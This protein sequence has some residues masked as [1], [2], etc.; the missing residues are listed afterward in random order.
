MIMFGRWKRSRKKLCPPEELAPVVGR[1]FIG[2][3]VQME[4]FIRCL[5]DLYIDGSAE[6]TIELKEH[7]LTVGIK[8]RVA[9]EMHV[10]DATISGHVKGRILSQGK[11]EITRSGHFVGQIEAGGIA[12]ADGAY[13]KAVVRLTRDAA[14]D[15]IP[16]HSPLEAWTVPGEKRM[17][18]T[19]G[20][21][22]KQE[23]ETGGSFE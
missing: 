16:H 12:V 3:Q 17:E 8:G 18:E 10:Q 13:L 4:G 11:V 14:S 9:A 19:P 21:G 22:L 7:R 1:T 20:P 15:T 5:E 6:G 23:G 2:E